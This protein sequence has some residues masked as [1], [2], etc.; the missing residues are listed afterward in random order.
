M[1]T[2]GHV[3]WTEKYRPDTL[4]DVIGH[5]TIIDRLQA[6]VAE[7]QIPH[8]LFAGR[9]GVGKTTSAVSLAKDLYG[10]KWQ[11]NFSETNASDDRGIN[12]VR[13]NI[14]NFA[15]TAPINA[16]YKIMFLDEADALT[17][18]AQQALRRTMEKYSDVCRFILS[19]NYS[20]K[21]I[22]P[23]QSRCAVFRFQRL[24][25]EDLK[26]Y[27]NKIE[28]GE[29]VTV[30]G[31]GFESLVRVANGDLRNV[32]N[33][34]QAASVL[35]DDITEDVIFDV[36]ASL[37]PG[38]VTDILNQAL[39]GAFMDARDKAS[40]LMVERGLDGLDVIKAV[41]REIRSLDIPE[42]KKLELIEELGEYEF[43][44]VQGGDPD[45]QI[46]AFLAQ[47]ANT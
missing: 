24:P 41:H 46:E 15:R 47:L 13:E 28:D 25:D 4:E 31:D 34:L 5:E 40:D 36:A 6:F 43:R 12:V 20:S 37:K 29:N 18:D 39:S 42:K 22:E 19:C 44:I 38:E 35:T 3:I 8:M 45:I 23:I 21:I 11:Q 26:T 14:K 10:D 7:N 27:V 17:S 9:A 2:D 1:A 32:T 30:T 33:I 16:D